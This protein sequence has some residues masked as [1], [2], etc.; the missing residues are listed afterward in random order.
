MEM[1][2]SDKLEKISKGNYSTLAFKTS[3]FRKSYGTISTVSKYFHTNN[4]DFIFISRIHLDC[5]DRTF[6]Y[7]PEK[8]QSIDDT[9]IGSSNS[10]KSH[11][12]EVFKYEIIKLSYE[13]RN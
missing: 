11:L 13:E 4:P 9:D 1:M 6:W 8:Q 5:H 7:R 2:I 10:R 3:T 12:C